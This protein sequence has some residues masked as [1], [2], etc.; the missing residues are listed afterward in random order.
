MGRTP[1]RHRLPVAQLL[2]D[3]RYCGSA[4]A[5]LMLRVLFGSRRGGTRMLIG[6]RRGG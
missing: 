6:S 4:G 1:A 5:P 3:A 2:P